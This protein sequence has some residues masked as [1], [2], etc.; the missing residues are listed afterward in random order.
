MGVY[1]RI[2]ELGGGVG[3]KNQELKLIKGTLFSWIASSNLA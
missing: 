3:Q 1:T 2:P